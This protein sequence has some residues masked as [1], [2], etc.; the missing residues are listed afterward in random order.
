M[1]NSNTSNLITDELSQNLNS[2]SATKS[3]SLASEKSL[4]INFQSSKIRLI[5]LLHLIF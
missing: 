4:T 5:C 2:G 3:D 1:N